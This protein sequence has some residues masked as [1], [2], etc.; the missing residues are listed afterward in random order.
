MDETERR[1]L[2][3]EQADKLV[4]ISDFDVDATV[5]ALP[6]SVREKLAE[7]AWPEPFCGVCRSLDVPETREDIF[8]DVDT[9]RICLNLVAWHDE[10]LKRASSPWRGGREQYERCQ[11]I[12]AAARRSLA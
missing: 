10:P 7:G 3:I 12:Y 1:A 8:E 4:D 2:L 6:V 11:A 9:V 5:A